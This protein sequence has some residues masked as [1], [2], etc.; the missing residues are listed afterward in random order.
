MIERNIDSTIDTFVGPLAMKCQSV[1]ISF[2]R[3]I[4]G[5]VYCNKKVNQFH[6]KSS[7]IGDVDTIDIDAIECFSDLKTLIIS[8]MAPFQHQISDHDKN[9]PLC[10]IWTEDWIDQIAITYHA[11][12]EFHY[13]DPASFR[14]VYFNEDGKVKRMPNHLAI[15]TTLHGLHIYV[16][17]CMDYPLTSSQKTCEQ[18][19]NENYLSSMI[20]TISLPNKGTESLT[21][22]SMNKT[23]KLS[24]ITPSN[25][26]TKRPTIT[27]SNSMTK[28]PT[29]TPSNSS[30]KRP[31][32][33]P[34]N[35]ST[36]RQ[37]IS[38]SKKYKAPKIINKYPKGKRKQKKKM[39]TSDFADLSF[40]VRYENKIGIWF[41]Y[42]D[43]MNADMNKELDTQ[44]KI[45]NS[46][47][48]I[49]KYERRNYRKYN[50]RYFVD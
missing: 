12:S 17:D 49:I 29:I 5:D 1:P 21:N 7:L 22:E 38:K 6:L 43:K 35:S 40:K 23:I 39:K 42:L 14:E 15:D 45:K 4:E 33:T 48:F 27:P 44:S 37:I 46:R 28:C 8:K 34:S 20:G 2:R 26:S 10:R 25:S 47:H 30:T 16:W 19:T 31:T 9:D 50:F 13:M 24:N 32:I 11:S 36:K 3:A 18:K 41:E